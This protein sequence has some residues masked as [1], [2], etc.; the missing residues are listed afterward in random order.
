MTPQMS[1]PKAKR[2]IEPNEKKERARRSR[3]QRDIKREF[4]EHFSAGND[5]TCGQNDGM[6]RNLGSKGDINQIDAF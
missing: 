4:K 2:K 6:D 3:W 1:R 5:S